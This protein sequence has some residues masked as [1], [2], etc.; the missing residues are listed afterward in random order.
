M[1]HPTDAILVLG[2]A[3]NPV[4]PGHVALMELARSVVEAD[5]GYRVLAGHLAVSPDGYV[6][7]KL[8]GQAMK[9]GHRLAMCNLAAQGHDW[10]VPAVK[11][12]GSA[13]ECGLHL[14]PRDDVRILVVMGAD[15]ALA[16]SPERAK[17]RRASKHRI[18]TVCVARGGDSRRLLEAYRADVG[19]GLV[20]DPGSF[21]F[22]AEE[23]GAV[24]STAVRAGLRSLHEAGPQDK[25]AAA[26]RLVDA[27]L[28]HPAVADYVL[29]RDLYLD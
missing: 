26:R 12:F 19:A 27:G 10:I 20:A 2:G 6:R 23:V 16:D 15:R 11:P 28:L 1:T 13:P 21:V 14:R 22:I 18:V 17:W 25:R 3:F 29:E 9:A 8:K 24:S 4:H 7:Q 5:H